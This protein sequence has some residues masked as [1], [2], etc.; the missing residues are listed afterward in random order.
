MIAVIC[1]GTRFPTGCRQRRRL[2][3]R[4]RL[5]AAGIVAF[6]GAWLAARSP[7]AAPNGAT[8]ASTTAT[9]TAVVESALAA[10]LT[11]NGA[12]VELMALELPAGACARARQV[13]RAEVQRP[14]EGSGRVAIKLVA[15]GP[16]GESHETCQ[17]WAWAKVRV[18]AKL[19]IARRPLRAGEALAGA[20]TLEEREIR[21]GV[22]PLVD[23]DRAIATRFI[24]A[25]QVIDPAATRQPGPRPGDGIKVVVVSG[26]LVVEQQGKVLSCGSAT[27][28]TLPS[29][30]RVEGT[31]V[32]GRLLVQVP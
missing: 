15:D 18:V 13:S 26:A 3:A 17:T 27:C 6:A 23:P 30:R 25:G 10:A 16:D 32:D 5:A 4:F 31:L 21:P 2:G 29:G 1:A 20:L 8:T 22:R 9:A 11:V 19:A 12:R 24:A 7:A 28:A 14:I